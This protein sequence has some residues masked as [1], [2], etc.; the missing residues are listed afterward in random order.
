MHRSGIYP[1]FDISRDGRP[2]CHSSAGEEADVVVEEEEYNADDDGDDDD[3]DDDDVADKDDEYGSLNIFSILPV[4]AVAIGLD[5]FD[6]CTDI[7][8]DMG[9]LE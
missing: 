8:I 1:A 5:I 2:T 4:A 7:R 9:K 6:D 3:G